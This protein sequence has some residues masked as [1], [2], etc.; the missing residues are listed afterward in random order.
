M[1]D[2]NVDVDLI[3]NLIY[4]VVSNYPEEAYALKTDIQKILYLLKLELDENNRVKESLP[5]YWYRHGPMSEPVYQGLER[6]KEM[7]FLDGEKIE[8]N[9]ER[10]TIGPEEPSPPEDDDFNIASN[11]LMDIVDHFKRNNYVFRDRSEFLEEEIYVHAPFEFQKFY[12]FD[13]LPAIQNKVGEESIFNY[14]EDKY[15]I[16]R[17][18]ILEGE[19]ILP[20]GPEFNDFNNCYSYFSHLGNI[21]LKQFDINSHPEGLSMM[22]NIANNLWTTFGDNLR[23]V[24]Y[25]PYYEDRKLKW[26]EDY[27]D[28]LNILN[29]SLDEFEEFIIRNSEEDYNQKASEESGWGV[30]AKEI[31][32]NER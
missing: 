24:C 12:K 19:S 20:L 15:R 8:E 23:L 16:I 18:K 26:L 6:S 27:E 4:K 1:G 21:Y 30:L 29:D 11:K 28:H 13:L 7:A 9:S 3:S 25:D 32:T 17:D 31:I 5:Y 2:R 14:A 22:K 10:Y